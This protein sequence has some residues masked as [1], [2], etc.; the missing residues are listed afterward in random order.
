M[1]W[2]RLSRVESRRPGQDGFV[3]IEVI[4]ALM[5]LI[6]VMTA[7][8]AAV[9]AV[10]VSA[11]THRDVV[12][13]G[14]ESMHIAEDL[15]RLQYGDCRTVADFKTAMGFPRTVSGFVLDITSVDYLKSRTSSTAEWVNRTACQAAGDQGLQ[16]IAVS[17]TRPAGRGTESLP[18][19]VRDRRCRNTTTTISEQAC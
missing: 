10:L 12:R 5:F 16:R 11:S 7:L 4:V 3:L 14:V 9:M 1:H 18:F 8:S 13:S 6:V 19:V 2:G 17:V 15:E